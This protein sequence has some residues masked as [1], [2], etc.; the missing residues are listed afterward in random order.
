MNILINKQ[1][2]ACSSSYGYDI[3]LVSIV[4]NILPY[5]VYDFVILSL[6]H[7]EKKK[8]TPRRNKFMIC[9]AILGIKFA[10]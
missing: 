3:Y 5:F 6:R 10:L 9:I 7:P 4:Q 1:I 2:G 8:R